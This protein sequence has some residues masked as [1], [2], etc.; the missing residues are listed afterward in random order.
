MRAITI[1]SLFAIFIGIVIKQNHS[2]SYLSAQN[3]TLRYRI[4]KDTLNFNTGFN[5]AVF[6]LNTAIKQTFSEGKVHDL[7][8]RDRDSLQTNFNKLN[9]RIQDILVQHKLK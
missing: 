3:D 1:I 9:K 6:N 2:I 8:N 7:S 4:M 5:Y